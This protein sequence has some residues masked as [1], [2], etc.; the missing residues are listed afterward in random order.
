MVM[1]LDTFVITCA[2]QIIVTSETT[3]IFKHE[4]RVLDMQYSAHS[5]FLAAWFSSIMNIKMYPVA[6]SSII[7]WFVA[8][9]Q[10]RWYEWF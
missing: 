3:R 2:F 8:W 9:P 10:P 7:F 5:Y 4:M 1:A 6:V